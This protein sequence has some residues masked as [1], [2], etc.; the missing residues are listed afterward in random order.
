MFEFCI[1]LRYLFFLRQH[2][3][4]MAIYG[5]ILGAMEEK[6]MEIANELNALVNE[7]LFNESPNLVA[8]L[9]SYS[10][11]DIHVMA[12]YGRWKELLEV[13]MPTDKNL[14]LY[15]T[16]SIFYGRALSWAMSGNYVEAKKE[17]DR[18]DNIRKNHPEASERI[19]HNNTVAALLAVDAV[20][21][22]G[23]I[24]YREGK[25][26]EGLSLLRK[27]VDLQDN[28]NFD[29]PW[30]KM[31]PIRH[32][33]GGLL[34]EQG[35]I[36][37]AEVVFRKDLGFHPR[38]P[39]ALVGLIQCLQQKSDL[40]CCKRD[41]LSEICMLKEQLRVQRQMEWADYDVIVPCECCIH[42]SE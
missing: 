11:T 2:N 22:R 41:D 20:M 17:A 15:R 18:F 36:N 14:M 4:H 6:G 7:A 8:Y 23:E 33:L 29:E 12:R 24:A 16:A 5:S 40:D 34:L 19:L 10:A 13:E 31:Q 27:A 28:L 26:E 1:I 39:W 25:H 32:A 35:Q 37:E 38:N 42:P 3:F 9:E 30:G 21:I